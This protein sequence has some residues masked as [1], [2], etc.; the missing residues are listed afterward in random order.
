MNQNCSRPILC[1]FYCALL[2][3]RLFTSV[4]NDYTLLYAV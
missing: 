3:K 1:L 2:M 4:T